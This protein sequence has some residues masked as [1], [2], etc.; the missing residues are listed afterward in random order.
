MNGYKINIITALFQN[1]HGNLIIPCR[2]PPAPVD[3]NPSLRLSRVQG[4]GVQRHL[5]LGPRGRL[6]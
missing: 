4:M 3:R 6:R 5:S 2:S 1:M